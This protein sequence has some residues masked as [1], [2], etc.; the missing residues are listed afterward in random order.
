LRRGVPVAVVMVPSKEEVDRAVR[1]RAGGSPQFDETFTAMRG[2][3]GRICAD[4][5]FP[6]FDLT[7]PMRDHVERHKEQVY[8]CWDGHWNP[9]GHDV[10]AELTRAFLAS[11]GLA[12]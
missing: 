11:R 10:A 6:F 8:Y 1:L 2:R 12:P 5:G 9:R 3:M 4:H 7:D